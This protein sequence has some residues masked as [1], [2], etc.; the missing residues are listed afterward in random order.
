MCQRTRKIV[1]MV[2]TV[3]ILCSNTANAELVGHWKFDEASGTVA[4]DS[5]G[6]GNN[7]TLQNGPIW[8]PGKISSALQFDGIQ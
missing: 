4:N 2:M 1:W 3:G 8:V 6:Y 7:G 5:S